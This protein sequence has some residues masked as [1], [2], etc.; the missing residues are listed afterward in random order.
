MDL[1]NLIQSKFD[2]K[3]LPPNLGP[4]I[5]AGFNGQVHLLHDDPTKVVKISQ[6]FYPLDYKAIDNLCT[7]RFPACGKV[8]EYYTH[9]AYDRNTNREF[10]FLI[11]KMEK[12]NEISDD[13]SRVFFSILSHEHRNI[14]KKFSPSALEEILK[15]LSFSLDFDVDKVIFFYENLKKLP[16]KYADLHEENIMKDNFGNF[17]LIDFDRI[18]F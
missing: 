15:G 8:F 4:K 16:F 11:Y 17:K 18:Y 2:Y 10:N 1:V 9:K 7:N 6:S 5:G 12:L 14:E 3:I 13:E